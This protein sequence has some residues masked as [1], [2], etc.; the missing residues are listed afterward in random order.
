MKRGGG[1]ATKQLLSPALTT[2]G[3]AVEIHR[4]MS[5]EVH[6]RLTEFSQATHDLTDA[7]QALSTVF[8]EYSDILTNDAEPEVAIASK[9]T[10][11]ENTPF[12]LPPLWDVC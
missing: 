6:A 10:F 4:R 1:E 2:A 11:F 8:K 12:P 7:C 9:K 3:E 5:S